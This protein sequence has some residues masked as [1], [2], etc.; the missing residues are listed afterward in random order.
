MSTK[1]SSIPRPDSMLFNTISWFFGVLFIVVGLINT[2]WGN[3][4]F[5][6]LFV[7]SLSLVFF[8]PV[9][10]IVREKTAISIPVVLKVILALF[11]IWSSL[12]VGELF[13]KITLMQADLGL[14]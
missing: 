13:Q 8:P 5:Y 4:T 9:M 3:D 2:F 7:I 1:S 10:A 14:R 6:G 12:G 11:I